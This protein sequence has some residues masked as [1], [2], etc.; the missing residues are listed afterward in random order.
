MKQMDVPLGFL[1][2]L[3]IVAVVVVVVVM[4]VAM[5]SNV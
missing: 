2:P 1:L 5:G 3:L 4:V